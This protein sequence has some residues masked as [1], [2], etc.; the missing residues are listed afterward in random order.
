M[1]VAVFFN[2][3]VDSVINTINMN[4]FLLLTDSYKL[5]HWS[6]YPDQTKAVYS[7][8][9]SRAG[10]EYDYTLFFGLQAL[11]INHFTGQV[12]NQ[13]KIE[14]AARFCA[15]HFGDESKFN[16]VGWEYILNTHEGRLPI[17][18]K[19]VPEGTCVP[20]GN[21]LMTVETTD[22]DPRCKFLTNHCETIGTHVWYPSTVATKSHYVKSMLTK[23][24]E[25]CGFSLLDFHLHDFG[26]RG[27]SSLESA[28]L[29]G[30]AHLVNFMGTDTTAG[31]FAA[32]KYYNADMCGFSVPASEHSV[33]TAEGPEGEEKY[34][35]RMIDNYPSGVVSIVAD[36]YNI[37]RFVRQY[38]AARKE[39]I[40]DRWI[41]GPKN[42]LNRVVIRPDSLRFKGDTAAD[43]V[44]W[45]HQ[46]LE[47]IFGSTCKNGFKELHPSIG[48]I[49][50]D[51]ISTPEIGDVYNKLI[52]NGYSI[53]NAV[54]GQGGGLL[55]KVNRDTQRFAFKC[56]SQL[57]GNKWVDVQK[58]PLDKSKASKTGRLKLVKHHAPDGTFT[59]DTINEKHPLYHDMPDELV[60]VFENGEIT[61]YWD[62]AEIKERA[63]EWKSST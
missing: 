11:L 21:V 20:T 12:I 44:L 24:G 55:Q 1:L 8:F 4:N 59:W 26:F 56:S 43:Q 35:D 48:V 36:S 51:G 29:G 60:T 33:A 50:G 2:P 27:V 41:S 46:E 62:W 52:E 7:Y 28:G 6:Q 54:V 45:L 57:Q 15:L 34:L 40:I 13:D 39:K 10:A 31:I 16:R 9:E 3:L 38:V 25:T 42:V 5:N 22:H 49:W 32:Q 30:M 61:K 63:S 17:R 47:K 58:N 53:S 14:E 23:F 19:A 18:I 37:E